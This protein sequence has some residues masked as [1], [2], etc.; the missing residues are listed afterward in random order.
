[1]KR[2]L[3]SIGVLVLTLIGLLWP[4]VSMPTRGGAAADDPVVVTDYRTEYTVDRNGTLTASETLATRFPSGR[5]GIFRYWDLVDTTDS[6]VRLEPKDIEVT[7]DG[8]DVPFELSW[9]SRGRFRV[10]RIG[11][12][13]SYVSPGI[14]TYRIEYRVEGVLADGGDPVGE[15]GSASWGGAGT[16]RLIWRVVPDGWDM[17]IMRSTNTV[18]LPAEPT[19]FSCAAGDGT[20]CTVS[21]PSPTTRVVTTGVLD[22]RTGVATRA[23]L[24]MAAPERTT[25]P[26]SIESDRILGTSVPV[27]VTLLVLAA[28]G[29]VVGL[30]WALRSRERSPLLPVM[31]GPP[32]DPTTA[33]RVLSPVQTYYVA[34]EKMPKHALVATLFHLAEQGAVALSRDDSGTW[35]VTSKM[36]P[37]RLAALDPAAGAVVSA[38]GLGQA[39]AVFAADRSVSAGSRLSTATTALSTSVSVWGVT[40]QTIKHSPFEKLGRIAVLAAMVCAA[41]AMILLPATVMGLPFAAFAVGGAG[42]FVSGVGTRRTRLGR[43]VWSRAGGFERLLSTPSN[44]DRLDFSADKELFTSFIPYAIAFDCADAWAAKYRH[45]TGQEPPEPSWFGPGL[46]MYGSAGLMGGSG[47][48]SAIDGFE[49]SLS[50]SIS[51]YTASQSS[52]SGGGFGGGGGGFGGGGGGG[53]GG[54]SW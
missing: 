52:S 16:S 19:A 2:V 7:M 47:G 37:D 1:M 28:I 3:L 51:A 41:V 29:F 27:L 26:W 35:T 38:L 17:R 32:D 44:L 9:E 21:A 15:S 48:M 23:D 10:A 46:Y 20:E 12:A 53:G 18:N 13:D 31:Y 34:Y 50:S 5:H 43:E 11:D 39:G 22:P 45:A 49:Q 14:H 24:P 6:G 8:S 42:L 4:A 40:S 33:G 25:L 54:G 36:T 30:L